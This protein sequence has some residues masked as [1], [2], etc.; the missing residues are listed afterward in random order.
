MEQTGSEEWLN[1]RGG[2]F[3]LQEDQMNEAERTLLMTVARAVLD[4]EAGSLERQLSKLDA[5]P[6]RLPRFIPIEQLA[7]ALDP[8][9]EIQRPAH[10]LF[11]NGTGGFTPDGREYVIYLE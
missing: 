8:Q 9:A 5:A 4:G 1:D 7:P 11:D 10:L 6:V 3:I 2:I